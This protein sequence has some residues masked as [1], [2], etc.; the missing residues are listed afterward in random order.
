MLL[1]YFSKNNF[2]CDKHHFGP[3]LLS[4]LLESFLQ[5]YDLRIFLSFCLDGEFQSNVTRFTLPIRS[6]AFNKSGS[7]LAAA[8]DDD[9]IKLIATIDSS[10]SKVLK[11]HKGPVTSLAFDPVN[12]YLASI[13]SLGTVIFWE[14]SSGKQVHVLNAVAPNCDSDF[15]L[16]NVLSWSPNGETLAVPGLRN[17]VVM[18]DRD[19]AEKMFTLKGDHERP[20]CFLSWSPNGKY[21]ATSSL[22]KQVLIWDVDL[23]Q[24]IERQKFDDRVCSLAWKPN[25]NALAVIDVLGKFGIWDSAVPSCMKSPTD[26]AS[27]FQARSTNELLF[28]EDE[29]PSISGSL[30]DE[31]DESHDESAPITHK[32]LRKQSILQEN[33]DENSDGADGLL[34]QIEKRSR[35]SAKHGI[36]IGVGKE[37]SASSLNSSRPKMQESFQSG[38]T[39]VQAGKRRFLAYNMLGSITTLENEGYYHI[40]VIR[41]SHLFNAKMFLL[42]TDCT[43]DKLV[44]LDL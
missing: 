4:P 31:V 13:D 41:I 33:S 5:L 35:S 15:S 18:Y 17:D 30:D 19:T 1:V 44:L 2:F 40:E 39:P 9:G 32:R 11:G 34:Y 7:L 20:V 43:A 38:S 23:R 22:D 8:G 14:L 37:K 6:L 3:G 27:N 24:D 21:I 12:E 26:G 25:G 29:N 36:R 42:D 10:I 16:I 28:G